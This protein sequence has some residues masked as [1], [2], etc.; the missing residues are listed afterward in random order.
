MFSVVCFTNNSQ[1]VVRHRAH[2]GRGTGPILLESYCLWICDRNNYVLRVSTISDVVCGV[3]YSSQ[4]VV[5]DRAHYGRGKGTILLAGVTCRGN[6]SSILDCQ[7]Q[8]MGVS[9]CRHRKVVGVDC[10]PPYG[11][12]SVSIT[13]PQFHITDDT[14]QPQ[15]TLTCTAEHFRPDVIYTWSIDCARQ[16]SY[17]HAS[18]CI[19]AL[20][21]QHDGEHV[22]CLAT[23]VESKALKASSWITLYLPHGP[24]SVSITGPQVHITDDTDKLQVTLTCTAA[25]FRYDVVYTWNIDCTRQISYDNVSDCIFTRTR[26]HDGENVTC[27]ATNTVNNTLTATSWITLDLPFGPSSVSVSESPHVIS[28]R[29]GV[30]SLICVAPDSKVAVTFTWGGVTCNVTNP[31]TNNSTC[32]FRPTLEDDGKEIVCNAS[33]SMVRGLVTTDTYIYTLKL[34]DAP[35]LVE[36]NSTRGAGTK[37]NPFKVTRGVVFTFHLKAYPAPVLESTMFIGTALPLNNSDQGYTGS[38]KIREEMIRCWSSKVISLAECEIDADPVDVGFYA[39]TLENARGDITVYVHVESGQPKAMRARYARFQHSPGREMALYSRLGEALVRRDHVHVE[40]DDELYHLIDDSHLG[41]ETGPQQAVNLRPRRRPCPA[42]LAPRLHHVPLPPLPS[43]RVTS[44][45]RPRSLP[46]DYLHPAA[47]LSDR[48][49]ADSSTA[50][51]SHRRRSLPSDYMHL[52]PDYSTPV[53]TLPYSPAQGVTSD[54]LIPTRTD[55]RRRKSSDYTDLRRPLPP[56]YL[57]P[58]TSR[59]ERRRSLP[60]DYIHP[61][62]T[63]A[64]RQP[65]KYSDYVPWMLNLADRWRPLPPDYIHPAPPGRERRRSLPSDYIHPIATAAERQPLKYSDY[66]PWMLNLAD[67]WRPLPPDYIHPAPPGRERRRSLPSDYIHPI[68]TAAERQPLK[69]SD[70]VPWMLNLADRWRPLPPD[71]IHPAP[72]GRERRRSLPSDYI[73]PIATAA[74]RQ[75]LKYSD[76]V[77]RMLNLADRWRPLPPDYIHPAPPGRE[78]R[79]SLPSDYIHSVS[80]PADR[81][82]RKPST[83]YNARSTLL[84]GWLLRRLPVHVL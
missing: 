11:P 33:Y 47:S 66:V 27:L 51:R 82:P 8:G 68:A 67:R 24:S 76:Y 41:P 56:D 12:S 22:T 78:R 18:K 64:E 28:T 14:D 44:R 60:S 43:E 46:D 23:N 21:R 57:H 54:Y 30:L 83:A 81:Q 37:N 9:N 26:Q 38:T 3:C 7:H 80:T 13:G 63:A 20:T 75:P 1:P 35:Q 36:S 70:Y 34:N 55:R 72:P 53:A 31:T 16:I 2:D 6:E 5:R 39:V 42:P 52:V 59:R 71:Y 61:I 32:T 62:A 79:R 4:P 73:H 29:P 69:Y 40:V 45:R 10:L 50:S 48:R 58:V 49:A 65:L 15:V 19:F 25:H 77:P 84:K 74:E 17:D